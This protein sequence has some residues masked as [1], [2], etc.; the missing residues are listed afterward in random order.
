RILHS[1]AVGKPV[2]VLHRERLPH[3][4]R[5]GDRH[6]VGDGPGGGPDVPEV[7]GDSHRG[8]LGLRAV[9]SGL[10]ESSARESFARWRWK[11]TRHEKATKRATASRQRATLTP[12]VPFGQATIHT[13]V[14]RR[15][16]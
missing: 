8:Y 6:A 13:A 1:H 2:R 3:E 12:G 14:P 9:A 7:G 10:K 11:P 4:V 16:T 15:F 5:E